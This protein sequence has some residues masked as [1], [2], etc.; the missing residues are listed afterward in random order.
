MWHIE[1]DQSGK[2]LQVCFALLGWQCFP[3]QIWDAAYK[4]SRGIL[5]Y[6]LERLWTLGKSKIWIEN[7][8]KNS[9]TAFLCAMSQT[10][11]QGLTL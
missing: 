5:Y 7:D 8:V 9:P 3:T 6:G 1:R 2:L 11:T 4:S 10:Q